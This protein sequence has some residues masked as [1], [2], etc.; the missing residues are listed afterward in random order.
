[1]TLTYSPPDTD[2]ELVADLLVTD[3]AIGEYESQ[4]YQRILKTH[5]E[6]PAKGYNFDLAAGLRVIQF[7][8]EYCKHHAG[9]W[10]GTP[11][12]L[13]NWQKVI[14][15]ETFGWKRADGFRVYRTLWLELGRKNG[16]SCLASAVALYLLLA[17]HEQGSEVYSSA[18]KRDQAKIVFDFAKNM[19]AQS[20]E[21]A[22]HCRV[23]R[24]NISVL[25]SSSK[26]EPLSAEGST[27]DGLNP[28]GI[29]I[30]ELHSHKTRE[31]YDKL[32]TACASR[33][34]PL[35]VC[36]TTAGLYDPAQIGWQL[37]EHA[38]SI[39][40]GRVEDDTWFCWI[41]AADEGDDPYTVE[42]WEKANPNLGTSVY[43][44]F[45]EQRSAEAISQPSSL[46]AF[47]RL[48]LN[49]WTKQ[50]ER[51]LDMEHWD[52]CNHEV[53][54]DE[55]E[56]RECYI[57]LD[58]SSKL[59]LTALAL[60]F[61]PTDDDLWRLSV[62]CYIP[63]ESMMERER[64]DRIPYSM[65]ERDGWITPT[66]GDVIDYRWIEKDIFELSERFNV[67]EVAYDPWSAQQMALR[68]RDDMG[69]SVVPIRQGFMSLSE[70]TKEFERLVVSG[71]L[72]HGG[73]SCLTWQ[74]NNVTCRH[75]PAGNIK[76]DKSGKTHKIDG[77]AASI[78][79]L[80]R[81]SLWDGGSV[82]E[83]EGIFVL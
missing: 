80:A 64:I 48:H 15:L 10:A 41:S 74:A 52:A 21:L 51:W 49:Q 66:E 75:D 11:M 29:I 30:D 32:V 27:L 72:A 44:S 9:E 12:L 77:I 26:F 70:P 83:E 13:E 76:P 78:I 22:K 20:N 25:R 37:H 23:Q 35:T 65:W 56:G 73:N 14:L 67:Q 38:T 62:N 40:A 69:L 6:W 53:N 60:I 4:A 54:L 17:D 3:R 50:V 19:V 68:I 18:T 71:K 31:V 55:L 45:L 28:H 1:M 61:P 34:Q 39:L 46:N 57:G 8:E 81:A 16:K 79:S 82:Y 58:L 7:V 36:I 5:E 59:D 24:G 43:P 2:A 42:T 47:T 33:R 63:R